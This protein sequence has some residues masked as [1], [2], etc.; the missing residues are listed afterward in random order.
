MSLL[1][2][3][4]IIALQ[5]GKVL[6][7][8]NGMDN[9]KMVATV[10]A[11]LMQWGYMLTK[12]AFMALSKADAGIIELF[13]NEVI[14]YLKELKGGKYNYTALYKNFP[15]EVMAKT[16]YE[17]FWDSLR[18]YW[19]NGKWSPSKFDVSKEIKFENVKYKMLDVISEKDFQNI[20]TT[21]VSI[22]TPLTPNDLSVVKWFVENE[23]EN[24]VFPSSIPLKENLCTLAA[25]KIEG[26]P[27]KTTT[28]VLRIAVHLSGGDISLPA[29]PKKIVKLNRWSSTKSENPEREKFK[30]KK[31]TR[32]ERKYILSLLE[33]SNCDVREMKLKAQRWI[34]LSEILHP[35]EYKNQYPKAFDVINKL[36]NEKVTSWYG[37]LNSKF[38]LSFN[39]GLMFLSQRPGEFIR[40]VDFLIRKNVK[41]KENLANIF[42]VLRTVAENSSNKVL[43]ELYTHFENRNKPTIGRS[44]FIK[45]AKKR[46]PLPDL[47]P[48]SKDIIDLVHKILFEVFKNKFSKLQPLGN[49]WID[50]NLKKI[51]VPTNMRTLELSE[52]PTVRGSRMPF[53]NTETKVIRAFV[54]WMDKQG[55]EDLDLSATFISEKT[56]NRA[57]ISYSGLRVGK[58]CHSGDVLRRKGPCAEYV[59][60]DIADALKLGYRYVVLDVR[61]FR[62]GSLKNVEAMFGIM[63][64]SHPESNNHW[65]PETVMNCQGLKSS[66]VGTLISILDLETKEYITLD[67]D[68]STI[69]VARGNTAEIL[70]SIESYIKPPAFSVY[71]LLLMHT[72]SRGRLVNLDNVVDTM[73]KFEDFAIS[74]E[75]TAQFML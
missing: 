41:N 44:I 28:D 54:H 43:F 36:R 2:N 31:F 1:L 15:Q 21:L 9:R 4:N 48:L 73:F 39:D 71:D 35:G 11:H 17:L 53:G 23:K 13:N 47:P 18:L 70:K 24:L 72:E 52:A 55:T 10:Q 20:F 51:P 40:R 58:S 46:T 50:E 14:A 22:N 64:R 3:K 63:E 65:L 57:V 8:D 30:F 56:N 38:K 62:G 16:D 34:R 12:D 26:L 61:N 19:S 29:V 33:N 45:G 74:Y 75:K 25:M 42:E 66:A 49:V 60:I 59:D 37:Q 68:S 7:I 69:P 6:S 32:A 5:K 67:L 27:I